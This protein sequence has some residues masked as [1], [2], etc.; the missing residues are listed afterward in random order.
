MPFPNGFQTSLP[1]SKFQ[2][3]TRIMRSCSPISPISRS[4]CALSLA[5][6]AGLIP[7]STY[8]APFTWDSGGGTS[9]W[10]TGANWNPDGASFNNTTDLTFASTGS[11]TFTG[12]GTAG[13]TRTLR[14]ITFNDSFT[15]TSGRIR[16]NSN[17]ASGTSI[18]NNILF[19]S[20]TGTAT[21][22]LTSGMT[23][24]INMGSAGAAVFGET[25]LASHLLIS[26]ASTSATLT[27]S[28]NI[29][30]TVA[31]RNIT[32][33]GAG[34]AVFAN[35]NTYSGT[36]T[37]NGGTLRINGT[38][39]GGG[40]YT[41]GVN[42][43]LQ[44]TGSTNSA[45]NVS[46]K[47]S[48]GASVQSFSSGALNMLTGSTFEYE[49]N[50]SVGTSAGADLQVVSGN[51]NL[52]GTVSL[53]LANLAAIPTAFAN[54]TT[55]S[56]INYSGAWNDGLF[57]IGGNAVADGGTFSAG[58]NVWEIDYD[59]AS[60]GLNFAGEHIAG[61]FVN[62]TAVPEPHA[63]ILGSIGAFALLRRR[64]L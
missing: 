15:S 41:V 9:S 45:L 58:L 25:Q 20:S 43:T 46:G 51:L 22:S 55:F 28:S 53:T 38:H 27:I 64:R 42:G 33:E 18:A 31:A 63:V 52:S 60:G 48:P 7:A 54:G 35:N 36:T 16:Y 39:T 5:L 2:K 4:H 47:L 13:G 37:V 40:G 12:I 11:S 61:G 30:E 3:P 19:S 24:S 62:I 50:S 44:G 21:I 49:L 23:G 6:A 56:L 17:G 10:G 34:L 29:T 1:I 59:A 8:A 26:H 57:T 32:K 14:S